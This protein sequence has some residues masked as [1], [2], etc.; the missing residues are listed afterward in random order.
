MLDLETLATRPNS[1]ILTLGAVK[2]NPYD[3]N[4]E[5]FSPI[6]L[7]PN[8]DAQIELG[9]AVSE[10]T[11]N[12]WLNQDENIRNDSMSLDDRIDLNNFISEIN[13]YCV[14]VDRVWCH[15]PVFDIAILEDLYFQLTIPRPWSYGQIRDSRTL[16]DLIGDPRNEEQ[17]H[18]HNALA[19]SFYQAIAVQKVYNRLGIKHRFDESSKIK[20]TQSP[21]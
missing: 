19:D 2:F 9:R 7:K 12:W 10:D 13:R 8:V 6:Y 20:N 21:I 14:G 16:F 1:V 4:Q 5:P 15:G 17:N 18:V 11:L 3:L